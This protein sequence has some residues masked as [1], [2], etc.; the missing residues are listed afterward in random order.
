[1][2]QAPGFIKGKVD[3]VV[4]LFGS[5]ENPFILCV[6]LLNGFRKIAQKRDLLGFNRRVRFV[7]KL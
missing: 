2:E 4:R 1:M 7:I 6:V 5:W 3:R